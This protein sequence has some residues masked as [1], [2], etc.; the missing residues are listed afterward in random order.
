VEPASL[1]FGWRTA[2]LLVVSAQVLV[3]ACALAVAPRNQVA[4]ASLAALLL[5][6]VG[7]L[8]PYTIGFAG[9]YDAWPQLTFAPFAAPLAIGPLALAYVCAWTE[10][11]IRPSLCVHLA[12]AALQF[13]YG[14]LCFLL[15][16]PQKLAWANGPDEHVSLVLAT[17]AP[18]SLLAYAL[19]A[20]ASLRRYR[21]RLGEVI[22]DEARYSLSWLTRALL[23]LALTFGAWAGFQVWEVV[24]G[25]L[26]YFQRLPLYVVI[27]A[28]ALYLAIE[29]WRH[30]GL[31][32]PN[33]T[34]AEDREQDVT[35]PA[36]DWR[37]MGERW[38]AQ[39]EAAGWWREP[40]LTLVEVAARLGTNTHYLS[41]A[42]NDGLGQTFSGFVN[43]LRA[44]AVREALVGG[45]RR[46]LT[47]LAFEA[48]FNSKASF[49]RAH[50]TAFGEA[51]S[52][53]R[54][55]A[56]D[57]KLRPRRREVRRKSA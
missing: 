42:L 49:N 41:R 1:V 39:V 36:R 24:S 37:G 16:L 11:P 54:R 2:I 34:H 31:N 38:S 17:L 27:A 53:A 43:G 9:A 48:G 44:R 18:A 50:L 21:R 56:S 32:R 6:L 28:L 20:A 40:E 13:V 15:P 47:A 19:A 51:P 5:V 35:R 4:N 45:D 57:P 7:L 25:G 29:G 46:P 23:A 22:T 14:V 30:A 33:L 55:R 52:V 3:L 26:S 12:P 8:T 10:R